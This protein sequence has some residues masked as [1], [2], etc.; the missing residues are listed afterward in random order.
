MASTEFHEVS[1]GSGDRNIPDYGA[2][3]YLSLGRV[4]DFR[5]NTLCLEIDEAWDEKVK[6][7]HLQNK[8]NAALRVLAE[9]G[10]QSAEQKLRDFC[11]VGYK[12]LSVV[13]YHTEMFDQVRRAFV[14]GAYYPA[15]VGASALGERILNHLVLDLREFFRETE[16]YKRVF[17][18]ASF[19]DW[20]VPI[21]VL[22]CWKVLLPET[23]SEF[24]RLREL[25][26]RS[27]HYNATTYLQLRED[28]LQA[29]GLIRSIVELQFGSFAV[30]P[31]FIPGTRGQVFIRRDYEDHPFIKTYFLPQCPFVGPLFSLRF[32]NGGWRVFDIKNYGSIAYSDEEFA[33]A[34]NTRDPS[35]VVNPDA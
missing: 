16:E 20:R 34:Y 11:D 33:S 24:R 1:T 19:D 22:E 29:A 25:R 7:L 15:L 13:S 27:I 6:E 30:R 31:W 18:K 14:A 12:P 4:F 3:R 28:A 8:E 23:A 26:N 5:A 2:R 21:N 32:G 9:F 17:R 10:V 35:L